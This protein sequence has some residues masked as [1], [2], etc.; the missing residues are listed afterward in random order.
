MP[1]GGGES[2]Y[3]ISGNYS[4]VVAWPYI[5][6]TDIDVSSIEFTS[7][8]NNSS[9]PWFAKVFADDGS[10]TKPQSPPTA[11]ADSGVIA[12]SN[13]SASIAL[14]L[15]GGTTYW[16]GVGTN[17]VQ[18]VALPGGAGVQVPMWESE[19]AS[20]GPTTQPMAGRPPIT[21]NGSCP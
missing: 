4:A 17:V 12:A 15:K 14:S 13:T 2:D 1:D 3:S 10:G 8:L 16:I 18:S 7:M 21:V 6:Q 9:V 19:F 11:L 20:W 5:P